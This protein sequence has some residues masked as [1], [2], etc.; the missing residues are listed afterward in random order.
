MR[1]QP[2]KRAVILD[3]VGNV[4]RF[5]MPD[6]DREW[7]LDGRKKDDKGFQ[8]E[9]CAY[10]Y[11][12]FPKYDKNGKLVKNCPN[13][14]EPIRAEEERPPAEPTEQEV[15]TEIKLEK[16]TD[17]PVIPAMPL[18]CKTFADLATYGKAKGYKPGWAYYMAKR[19]GLP[20]GRIKHDAGA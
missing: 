18:Q 12:S 9:T 3:H 13:C 7:S 20:V 16:V 6:A 8:I 4:K 15:H 11:Y 14:G 1:Y 19:M 2:D 5:G 10:C 17:V